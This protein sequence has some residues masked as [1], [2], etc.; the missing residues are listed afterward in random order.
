[1]GDKGRTRVARGEGQ[2]VLMAASSAAAMSLLLVV[3][4]GLVLPRQGLRAELD[5]LPPHWHKDV[6]SNGRYGEH[7]LTVRSADLSVH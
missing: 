7:V 6:D 2:R 5:A 3:V 1:M 4:V